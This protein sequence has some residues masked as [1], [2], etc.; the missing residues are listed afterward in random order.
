MTT[1]TTYT[2]LKINPLQPQYHQININDIAHALSYI[3]RGNGHTSTFFS[4]A[5][6]CINC[7]KEAKER[8]YSNKIILACLLHD[9]SEA[10]ICDIPK[11]LACVL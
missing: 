10:Y 6:H 4:V 8:G 5:Q 2:G 7:A 11:P 3:C 9:A 1:I